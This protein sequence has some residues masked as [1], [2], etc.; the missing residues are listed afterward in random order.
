LGH[1]PDV[2]FLGEI[3]FGAHGAIREQTNRSKSGACC[4]MPNKTF[5]VRLRNN[6]IQQ[7]RADTVEIHGS[8]L[9]FLTAKGKLAA[10]FL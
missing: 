9:A 2:D 4:F 7:V 3:D 5:L 8:H 10:L 6:A 1:C